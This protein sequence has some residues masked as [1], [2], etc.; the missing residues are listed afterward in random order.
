MPSTKKPVITKKEFQAIAIAM[1]SSDPHLK[2]LWLGES[3]SKV[4]K[5]HVLGSGTRWNKK[6][7]AVLKRILYA[8]RGKT[9]REVTR[10]TIEAAGLSMQPKPAAD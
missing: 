4:I 9:K 8:L 5:A 3:A 2:G 10:K 6:M 7:N 1:I